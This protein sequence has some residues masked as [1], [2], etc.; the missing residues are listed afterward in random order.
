MNCTRGAGGLGLFLFHGGKRLYS[1][2]GGRARCVAGQWPLDSDG[3]VSLVS[4]GNTLSGNQH[5]RLPQTASADTSINFSL[6]NKFIC[7]MQTR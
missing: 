1:N 6:H 5:V 4:T 2:V 3:L 7:L